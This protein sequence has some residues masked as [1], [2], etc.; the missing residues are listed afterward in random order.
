MLCTSLE[1]LESPFFRLVSWLKVALRR[2]GTQTAKKNYAWLQSD[3]SLC[4][5]VFLSRL[6]N[7][8]LSPWQVDG[9]H[10]GASLTSHPHQPWS[11]R[12]VSI[13]FESRIKENRNSC[14]LRTLLK[15]A[16]SS[17]S[18]F[19]T[20]LC[21]IIPLQKT[22]CLPL[23]VLPLRHRSLSGS[24]PSGISPILYVSLPRCLAPLACFCWYACCFAALLH[25]QGNMMAIVSCIGRE[26]TVIKSLFTTSLTEN[27]SSPLFLITLDPEQ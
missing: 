18:H 21:R 7:C 16:T 24:D 11:R 3:A 2:T 15:L 26:V 23:H 22:N 14:S 12:I 17:P 13:I 6:V 10:R 5:A 4:E 25:L 8:H 1:K 19:S 9:R 20:L 27:F